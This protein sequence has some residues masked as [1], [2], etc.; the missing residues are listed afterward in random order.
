M[1]TRE[2]E[3]R[4]CRR[5]ATVRPVHVTLPSTEDAAVGGAREASC[6]PGIGSVTVTP[7]ASALPMLLT[8][9]V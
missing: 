8:V 3:L 7:V 9:I 1:V 5:P 6:W 2:V 4:C